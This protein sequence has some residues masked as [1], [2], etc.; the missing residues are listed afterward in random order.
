MSSHFN[1]V[2]GRKRPHLPDNC[3]TFG[4]CADA[5]GNEP[6]A[7]RIPRWIRW[8]F[9]IRPDGGDLCSPI[10]Y[11]VSFRKPVPVSICGPF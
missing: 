10:S 2:P 7:C 6:I 4:S 11:G 9:D 5:V 3:Q 1:S 8:A